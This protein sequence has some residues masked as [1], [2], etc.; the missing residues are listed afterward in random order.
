MLKC[1]DAE[2]EDYLVKK[3]GQ[4]RKWLRGKGK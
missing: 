3:T 1:R 4:T 2:P